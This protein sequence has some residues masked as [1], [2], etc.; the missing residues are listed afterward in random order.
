[1]LTTEGR[2]PPSAVY[3]ESFPTGIPIPCTHFHKTMLE[4][5]QFHFG[6][7]TLEVFFCYI[8]IIEVSTVAC[9]PQF[10]SL[11]KPNLE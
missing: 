8:S 11:F 2:T 6:S 9:E 4:I 7:L 10:L 1:M 5:A 3:K